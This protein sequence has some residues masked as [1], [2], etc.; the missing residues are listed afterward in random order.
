MARY[1]SHIDP[2]KLPK[3]V[4]YDARGRGRWVYRDRKARKEI[5]IG[6]AEITLAELWQTVERLEAGGASTFKTLSLAFQDSPVWSGLAKSTQRDYTLCH[7]AIAEK[8]TRG[9]TLLGDV[10]LEAWTVG[11]VRRYRDE[12]AKTT[13]S[14]AKKELAYLRRLFAWAVEYEYMATNPAAAVSTKGMAQAR[15]HYV[16]DDDYRTLLI[17]APLNVALMAHMALLTGR[18]RQDIVKLRR[19]DMELEGVFF[20]ESKTDKAALV[21]WTD[22]LRDLVRLCEKEAGDSI[23]LFP[24]RDPREHYS[25]SALSSSWGDTMRA[26][27]DDEKVEKFVRF[28]FKDL[29]AKHAS[30]LEEAGGD[31]TENLLHSGRGVTKRHYLRKPKKVVSL[32]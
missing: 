1:P 13:K 15:T 20:E 18:R 10:P 30:D 3:N 31:A 9:G 16:Q 7:N 24:A 5:R 19:S 8:K 22:E 4:Y 12:R 23:W 2:K 27:R 6:G 25:L 21:Q 29:R 28:Q 32:R 11:A 17:H 26:I 14:R